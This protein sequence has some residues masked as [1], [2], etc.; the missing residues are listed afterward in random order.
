MVVGTVGLCMQGRL[1]N[2]LSCEKYYM[3]YMS[4]GALASGS[5]SLHVVWSLGR[6]TVLCSWKCTVHITINAI[7]LL[8]LAPTVSKSSLFCLLIVLDIKGLEIFLIL[9]LSG[10]FRW[11]KKLDTTWFT[12]HQYSYWA[13]PTLRIPLQISS[14]SILHFIHLVERRMLHLME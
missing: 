3:V 5:N 14:T 6:A 12:L 4:V 13:N 11:P 10:F 2:K 1:L 9:W 8:V 7:L